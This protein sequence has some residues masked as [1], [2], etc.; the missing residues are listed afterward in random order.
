MNMNLR[1]TSFNCSGVKNIL[2][3]IADLCET[4]D[5]VLLQ[6]TWLMPHDLN[7]LTAVHKDFDGYSTSAVDCT[8][9]LIGRPYGGLS[10]L[11]RKNMSNFVKPSL[12]DD[13]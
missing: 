12:F 3:I 10:I 5:I 1:I 2:P 9:E 13:D 6:E 11:W 7:I 8:Q 4:N